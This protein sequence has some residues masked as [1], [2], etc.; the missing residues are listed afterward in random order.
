[1]L[2]QSWKGLGA[3]GRIP[4]DED[5][6]EVADAG[7]G[8]EG[9][10]EGQHSGRHAHAEEKGAKRVAL[11]DTRLTGDGREGGMPTQVRRGTIGP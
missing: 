6:V 11:A 2:L 3:G 9:S 7:E 8:R 10:R 5:V 1:V 4:H